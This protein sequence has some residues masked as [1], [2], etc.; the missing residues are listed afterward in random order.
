MVRNF[1]KKL[2]KFSLFLRTNLQKYF[3]PSFLNHHAHAHYAMPRA[4][5]MYAKGSNFEAWKRCK[6]FKKEAFALNYIK[7]KT[8]YYLFIRKTASFSN[9]RFRQTVIFV[10]NTKPISYEILEKFKRKTVE[11]CLNTIYVSP[12][13]CQGFYILH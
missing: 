3:H 12:S 5:R 11:C 1:Y 9:S 7:T 2:I 13:P 10:W 8:H 4:K 6:I